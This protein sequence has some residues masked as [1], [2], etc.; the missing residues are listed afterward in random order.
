MPKSNSALT[1][2]VFRQHD[3]SHNIWRQG[4]R[5]LDAIFKPKSIAIV[6]ATEKTGSVGRTLLSNLLSQP[7]GGT[8]Y[9]VNPH[10]ASVLGV[11]AYPELKAIPEKVELAVII[12]PAATVPSLVGE[13]VDTGVKGVVIISAGFKELGRPGEELESRILKESRRG[14]IR[15]IGPNCLGVM[16][17][18]T[19][20]NATFASRIARSGNVALISQSGAICTAILDWSIR[21]HVG[22]SAFVSVGSMLDVGWG[23][24]IDYLGD[25]P[26]TK[27]ILIY[28]E[29]IGDARSFLSAAREVAL[30]KPII[31]LKAGRT[32]Q[33]AKAAASHTGSIAGSDE[34]LDA[35]FRRSGVLRVNEIQELF[36]MAEILAKQPRPCGPKLSIVTNAGGPG[37]LTTD[38]L[39]TDGGELAGIS[40]DTFTSLNAFLP[41]HWS[42]N[43]PIDILGDADPERYAK[44]VE[45]V[46]KDPESHGMLVILTPQAMTDPTKTAELLKPYAKTADR[47]ILASWMG[48][49]EVGKGRDILH[50]AGIP[51]FPYPEQAARMFHYMWK[52][53]RNLQCLYETPS[54]TAL[55]AAQRETQKT[56]C[57]KLIQSAQQSG[58]TV[59][60]EPESKQVLSSYGIPV[61]E[62]L[63]ARNSREALNH[64]KKMGFPA[65]LKLFSETITHKTDVGGV[66]LNLTS[67]E[68]VERAYDE[69]ES[70]VSQKKSKADFLGVTVQP[71]VQKRG[72]E[73]IIGSSVDAQFGPVILF[74]AGGEL[75][76]ILKDCTLALPPLN[77]TLARLMIE[78]TKIFQVLKGVRGSAGVDFSKLEELLVGF[79]RLVIE[80]PRIKEVDINPLLAGE[81][82]FIA[83]DARVVLHDKR[84]PDTEL[85]RLS[86]RPYPA[87]YIFPWKTGSGEPLIIRPIRPEDEPLMIQ[88][89]KTLSE[90]TVRRRYFTSIGLDKRIAHERLVRVCFNDYDREIAL[91]AEKKGLDGK[92]SEITGIA[93]LSR[94]SAGEAEFSM[95]IADEYQRQG[96]GTKLLSLLIDVARHEKMKSIVAEILPDN[97][98]IQHICQKLGFKTQFDSQAEVVRASFSV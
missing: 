24:L 12:T 3:P 87:E 6:G 57:A 92:Q 30:N 27:S 70:S 2:K 19:G 84:I 48:G 75:V 14:K 16:N 96:L 98:P 97:F 11:K 93:R 7:F 41:E 4:S 40:R 47:P 86:I 58:R 20:M 51:A 5:P 9:P 59:L 60:T 71:M 81:D 61:V 44:T 95:V 89:H 17:P 32:A 63:I 56:S 18:T 80:E 79:S 31:V 13:C 46:S 74:G 53:S 78:R 73:L 49:K 29:T 69:I 23:D 42:H 34:V 94:L 76:E 33:A 21:E 35:A 65:V 1:E 45:V 62:T 22:F 43:N 88:F 64:A 83:L 85:P 50:S 8:V 90:Q 36:D 28:M 72:V 26:N 25:D 67:A 39:I 10:R 82:G 55:N 37:V 38:A 54:L 15:I 68:A 66:K 91:V 52:Y 77:T